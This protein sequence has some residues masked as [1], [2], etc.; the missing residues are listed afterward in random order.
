VKSGEQKK[1]FHF[2]CFTFTFICSSVCWQSDFGENVLQNRFHFHSIVV[3]KSTASVRFPTKV[4]GI[5][6]R[7]GL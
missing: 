5:K 3:G 6:S 7:E 2:L 4:F 1:V